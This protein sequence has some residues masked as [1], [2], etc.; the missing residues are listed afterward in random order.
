MTCFLPVGRHKFL[1]ILE[2]QAENIVNI[3]V[4]LMFCCL[5]V[6]GIFFIFILGRRW[7]SLTGK[8]KMLGLAARS[9][10]I[11]CD[12]CNSQYISSPSMSYQ[13]SLKVIQNDLTAFFEIFA[14]RNSKFY[15]KYLL[16]SKVAMLRKEN[17]CRFAWNLTPRSLIFEH[18]LFPLPLVF[19]PF[20]Q[21][22]C[23]IRPLKDGN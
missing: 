15:S 10:G 12:V 19:F 13:Q 5:R 7:Q 1:L 11:D 3:K 2:Y 14:W 17:I 4:L 20:N 6:H 16:F 22:G 9:F 8:K 21:F 23:F 18:S